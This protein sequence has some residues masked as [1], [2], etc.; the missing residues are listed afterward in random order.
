MKTSKS[1]LKTA[2]GTSPERS[3][4]FRKN[5]K[6]IVDKLLVLCYYHNARGLMRISVFFMFVLAYLVTNI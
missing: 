5:F 4:I 2:F 1:S 3:K 6:K